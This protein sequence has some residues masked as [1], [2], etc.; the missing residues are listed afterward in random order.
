MTKC[1]FIAVNGDQDDI[2][3]LPFGDSSL[4]N[5][6]HLEILGSHISASGL[7]QDELE[8]HMTK[9]YK[10]C[11]KFY[12]FCRE[13]KLAPLSVKIKALKA[14]V[15]SSLL[16]NC[17]TFGNKLPKTLEAVYNK[18]L[19]CALQVRANTP[20][21]LLYIETG[22]LPIKALVEVRHLKYFNR[23]PTTLL[24]ASNRQVLFEKL[25]EDPSSYLKYYVQ[26]AETYNNHHEIYSSHLN[27]IKMKIRNY[28]T[29]GQ[30]KYE[31]YL[32]IN[33][34]LEPSP[35]LHCIHPLTTDITRFRLGSHNLPI[36]KGRW[37][38]TPRE[39]RI[40]NPCNVLGD[41]H[42]VI[43]DCSLLDRQDLLLSNEISHI[44]TQQDVFQLFGR[45]KQTDYL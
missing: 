20:I 9:R 25:S 13:N 37:N 41:E 17:E 23:F 44:W 31:M 30:Y 22:L 38:R 26:L 40:C 16:Y 4:E 32:K 7:L 8:L 14:C 35:L 6:D 29:N 19:R 33:P 39:L 42:H 18:L 36:E 1:K 43:Y 45:L 24:E 5:V 27:S 3:P 34:N 21:L 12:N 10:S 28:A 2:E 11:I 15:M